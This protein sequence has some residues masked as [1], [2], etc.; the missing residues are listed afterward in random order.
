V[1]D[2][3]D[4]LNPRR[5]ART[6]ASGWPYGLP[7]SNNFSYAPDAI[8]GWWVTDNS[9]PAN[10]KPVGGYKSIAAV[11]GVQVSGQYAY[12]SEGD[13]RLAVVN[14]SDPASPQRVGEY[15]GTNDIAAVVVVDKYAYAA[16]RGNWDDSLENSGMIGGGLQVIDISDAANPKR[17]GW[18]EYASPNG[19]MWK[20]DLAVRGNYAYVTESHPSNDDLEGMYLQ[21]IDISNP[22]DMR[23]IG[24]CDFVA[25]CPGVTSVTISGN[26][27]YVAYNGGA[28]CTCCANPGVA[29]IDVSDPAHPQRVGGCEI[30][31]A[32]AVGCGN[33]VASGDRV[34]AALGWIVCPFLITELPA[35]T[36]HSIANGR[37]NLQWNDPAKGMKLQRATS[38]TTPDWQDL[39]G[40]EDTNAVSLPVSGGSEFFRLMKR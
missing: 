2:I 35:I 23:R 16:A 11:S 6:G 21:I 24:S 27:V 15:R 13:G 18:Y 1:I 22:G 4:P 29:M 36:R 14:V 19:F 7:V 26:Y 17:I 5:V 25:G 10:P 9:D 39:L 30:Y 28:M 12:V 3:A 20:V 40:S 33:V 32:G 37:L 38:L 31:C 8:E 34:Y